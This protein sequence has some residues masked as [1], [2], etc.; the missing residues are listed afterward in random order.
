MLE[1]RGL[2]LGHE[3]SITRATSDIYVH[4]AFVFVFVVVSRSTHW[5]NG[6]TVH[7]S[8]VVAHSEEVCIVHVRVDLNVLTHILPRRISSGESEGALSRLHRLSRHPLSNPT[9]V[10]VIFTFWLLIHA[11]TC[12]YMH[13]L[14]TVLRCR[15]DH[16][17]LLKAFLIP[18]LLPLSWCFAVTRSNFVHLKR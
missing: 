14:V 18:R 9:L 2:T 7:V 12:I 5:S 10:L 6:K 13:V 3:W 8:S 17:S 1:R 11:F 15:I 4:H 16:I